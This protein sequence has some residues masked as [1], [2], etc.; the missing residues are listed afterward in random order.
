MSEDTNKINETMVETVV[1]SVVGP[2]GVIVSLVLYSV[3]DNI[4]GWIFCISSCT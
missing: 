3:D 2:A 4:G 1:G